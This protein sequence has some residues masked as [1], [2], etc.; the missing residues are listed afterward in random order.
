M[1][2]VVQVV[3]GGRLPTIIPPMLA[4]KC[5]FYTKIFYTLVNCDGLELMIQQLQG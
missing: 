3:I 4:I 2:I 5:T 1:R